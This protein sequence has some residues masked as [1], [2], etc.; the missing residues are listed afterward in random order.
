MVGDYDFND[1]VLDVETRYH[2]EQKTN[3]IKRIQLDV[4]L[5]AAG[6]TKALGVGLRITGINKSDIRKSKPEATI[7]VSR[8]HS[9]ARTTNSGTITLLIWKIPIRVS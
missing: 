2:R 9:T 8:S 4:T 3:H 6:A 7:R 1:V 5:A